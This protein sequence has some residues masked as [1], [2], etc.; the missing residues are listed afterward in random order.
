MPS[1][2]DAIPDKN[3]KLDEF[4]MLD[5]CRR[6]SDA[7]AIATHQTFDAVCTCDQ[8]ILKE[9]VLDEVERVRDQ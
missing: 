2:F 9:K 3:K 7:E 5:I 1:E 8:D 6:R 4:S